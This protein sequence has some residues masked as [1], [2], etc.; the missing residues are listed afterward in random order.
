QSNPAIDAFYAELIASH[1]ER[2]AVPEDKVGDYDYCPWSC[3]LDYS[4][5][6]VI[7]NC[8]WSKATYVGRFVETLARK[9]GLVVYDPQSEKVIS[10]DGT[11]IADAGTSRTALSVLALFGLLFAA[12]FV[13]AAR[14]SSSTSS[15]VCYAF[16]ALCTLMAVVCLRQAWKATR[17]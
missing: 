14:I 5:G 1:P 6:H 4:P 9:H 11:A 16:G 15:L 10:P 13:Y 17:P 3:E 7:V 12:M 8:V 2:N